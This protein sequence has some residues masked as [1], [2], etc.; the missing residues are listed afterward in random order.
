MLLTTIDGITVF[1]DGCFDCPFW[2]DGIMEGVCK[3]PTKR[4]PK[5]MSEK[6]FDEYYYF[7]GYPEDCPLRIGVKDEDKIYVAADDVPG[8]KRAVP[9]YPEA[10][11]FLD[12][13]FYRE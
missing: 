6:R 1:I 12:T 4:K 9:P 5:A 13:N 11:F 2:N 8:R 3:Y 10:G 7:N